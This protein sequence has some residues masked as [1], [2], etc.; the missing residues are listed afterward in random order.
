[1][2]HIPSEDMWPPPEDWEEVRISWGWMMKNHTHNAN[3]I[4]NLILAAPGGEFHLSGYGYHEGFSYRFK[5]P[6]DATWIR[7]NLPR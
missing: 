6:Q 3:D 1:M 7:L 2:I 5:R 4:Y